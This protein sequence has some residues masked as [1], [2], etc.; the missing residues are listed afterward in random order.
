MEAFS[1]G[2]AHAT[3]ALRALPLD[4]FAAVGSA[5]VGSRAHTRR[6]TQ[7]IQSPAA[8]VAGVRPHD[9]IRVCTQVRDAWARLCPCRP[10]RRPQQVAFTADAR[11]NCGT[12]SCFIACARSSRSSHRAW[13]GVATEAAARHVLPIRPVP[14]AA[15]RRSARLA[16]LVYSAR[17]STGTALSPCACADASPCVTGGSRVTP[18]ATTRQTALRATTTARS[19]A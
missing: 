8:A 4:R 19:A 12:R 6:H 1:E 15:L 16:A 7:A 3:A 13:G 14:A 18:T 2:S 11:P 5:V 10:E 9:C 17:C